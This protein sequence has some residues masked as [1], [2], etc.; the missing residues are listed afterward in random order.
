MPLRNVWE[1]EKLCTSKQFIAMQD[2][3]MAAGKKRRKGGF[4]MPLTFSGEAAISMLS[5]I[6]IVIVGNV[7]RSGV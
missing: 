1:I 6:E 5:S 7:G 2:F 4:T 3:E